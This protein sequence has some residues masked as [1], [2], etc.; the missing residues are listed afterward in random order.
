MDGFV[1]AA[2]ASAGPRRGTNPSPGS[3]LSSCY[4]YSSNYVINPGRDFANP[5]VTNGV[6]YLEDGASNVTAVN[7]A[8]GRVMWMHMY[9][10]A[11]Y[12]PKQPG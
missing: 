4:R 1:R 6:V 5:V 7:S 2:S 10:S 3:S 11:D 8:T 9:R 12:G